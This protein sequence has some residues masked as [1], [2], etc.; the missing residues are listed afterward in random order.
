MKL[1]YIVRKLRKFTIYSIAFYV[2]VL[3]MFSP[4]PQIFAA[5]TSLGNNPWFS[6][7]SS[8]TD[9]RIET[10]IIIVDS[11][12]KKVIRPEE[13]GFAYTP[14]TQSDDTSDQFSA[15]DYLTVSHTDVFNLTNFSDTGV[16][17]NSY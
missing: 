2:L 6:N 14:Q 7:E 13:T 12:L 17:N 11:A 16:I 10:E 5:S 8:L 15:T 3:V 9:N 4:V 1:P